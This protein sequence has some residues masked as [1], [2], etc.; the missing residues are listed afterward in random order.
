MTLLIAMVDRERAVMVADRRLTANGM[1]ID[2]DSNKAGVLACTDGR[3]AVAFTGLAEVAPTRTGARRTAPPTPGEFVT[4]WWL[5]EAL[6]KCA[7]PD[8]QLLPT[9]GRFMDEATRRFSKPP[10]PGLGASKGLTVIFAGYTFE[11]A[12][13]ACLY[14][15]SNLENRKVVTGE[16]KPV[17]QLR[18]KRPPQG[19]AVLVAFEGT[20]DGIPLGTEA[21]LAAL[22]SEGRP[23]AALVNKGVDVIRRAAASL[24]SGGVVGKTC[25]SVVLPADPS[26]AATFSYHTEQATDSIRGAFLVAATPDSVVTFIEPETRVADASGV[27]VKVV[28]RVGRNERCPCGSG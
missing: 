2:D 26:M 14:A 19:P 22:L 17:H 20:T 24:K 18:D 15:F 9:L 16:F 11:G 27:P 8:R 7:E 10:L 4:Q 3:V 28:S 12:P 25:T 5:A 21:D 23:S 1:L 13:R 6:S